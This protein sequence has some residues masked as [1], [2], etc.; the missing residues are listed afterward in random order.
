[1]L[2][3]SLAAYQEGVHQ[4]VS[5]P[6]EDLVRI[7]TGK[8]AA[9]R[10]TRKTDPSN[11][12][13]PPFTGAVESTSIP[14]E[15]L[16]AITGV[17]TTPASRARAMSLH[18]EIR[19]QITQIVRKRDKRSAGDDVN[20]SRYARQKKKL[21]SFVER[22]IGNGK[23]HPEMAVLLARWLI[24]LC[25]KGT[26]E[27]SNLR[28]SSCAKYYETL[29]RPLLRTCPNVALSRLNDEALADVYASAIE[30]VPQ[31]HQ[32]YTLGRL[33]EFHRFMM[34]AY[35]LPPVDWLDIA[36]I[37]CATAIAVD[38]GFVCWEEYLSVFRLL[39]H[40]P[41]ADLRT[42]HIQAVVWFFIYR[43]GARVSEAL[44][45]RRKDIVNPDAEPIVLFRNNDYREIKSDAGIRQVP[46]IGPLLAEERQ[47]LMAW[48]EHIAEFADD[49]SLAAIFAEAS[50]PREL[51]DRR[52]ICDRITEALRAVT[53]SPR[54][55]LHYGR[56]SFGTRCEWLMTLEHLPRNAEISR[57]IRRIIGP[58]DP[59][60]AR[61]LLLDTSEPSKRGP[62]AVSLAIGHAWPGTTFRYYT[63]TSDLLAAFYLDDVF[64]Q[65]TVAMDAP[66]AAYAAG[67]AVSEAERLLARSGERTV[68]NEETAR[69]HGPRNV[70][71]CCDALF[72]TRIRT[73]PAAETQDCATPPHP[74]LT[75]RALDLVHR[76]RRVDGLEQTLFLPGPLIR[77]L[78]AAE[79]TVRQAA[80]YDIAGSGWTPTSVSTAVAHARAG[81]RTS[82]ETA[83]VRELLREFHQGKQHDGEF[84][85]LSATVCEIWALRYTP[86]AT[87]LV[88]PDLGE[89]SSLLQW[90]KALGLPEQCIEVRVPEDH[91]QS[92][93][94]LRIAEEHGLP[95]KRYGAR[96]GCGWRR[97][98]FV[99]S[100]VSGWASSFA[101]TPSARSPA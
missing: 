8:P 38:A 92:A 54:A 41:D 84:D 55:R 95:A 26:S 18:R 30:T 15:P 34:D 39:L 56:H 44:G 27:E 40:D 31:R 10:M 1:M 77:R 49:D 14:S 17:H 85:Q 96:A 21:K 7:L 87:E 90:C 81:R 46:L 24:H 88:L 37:D 59:R 43:Y 29:A 5:L 13:L 91:Q 70:P 11:A 78:L 16:P 93:E 36:P 61:A 3:G 19:H 80:R 6:L 48:M 79:F 68:L 64:K 94:L 4:A 69:S 32:A 53:G 86:T 51:I 2:P 58:A 52:A 76:R 62:W 89:L 42:R 12:A 25:E 45:L 101:K 47:A 33:K 67:V 83:R 28:A 97:I 74:E 60:E 50:K 100:P 99:A 20:Y 82:A 75:D 23:E 57:V 71:S 22:V 73:R 98:A 65:A 63:H 35:G 72:T 9:P 66:T